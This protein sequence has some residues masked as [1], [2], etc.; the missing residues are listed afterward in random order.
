[1][2]DLLDGIVGLAT[3]K[4]TAFSILIAIKECLYDRNATLVELFKGICR[5]GVTNLRKHA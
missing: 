3:Q 5:D 1:M 4:S 2:Y